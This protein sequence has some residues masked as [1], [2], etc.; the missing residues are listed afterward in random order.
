MRRSP[1]S[2]PKPSLA[3]NGQAKPA[4]TRM[5]PSAISSRDMPPLYRSAR[6]LS[7]GKLSVVLAALLAR[8]QAHAADQGRKADVRGIEQ[9]GVDLH[10]VRRARRWFFARG[11]A[12]AN[13]VH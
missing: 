12:R 1:G 3:R 9:I 6:R 11:S 5:T 13:D 7:A 4:T 8:G 2:R 10:R